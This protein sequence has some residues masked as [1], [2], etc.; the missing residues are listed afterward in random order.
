MISSIK[1]KFN[2]LC[3]LFVRPER[4][5]YLTSELGPEVFSYGDNEIK[6]YDFQVE[7]FDRLILEASVFLQTSFPSDF[8]ILY[9]HG[10]SGCRLDSLPILEY[11]G[12]FGINVAT[13][14]FSGTGISEGN[15]VTLGFKEWK[16]VKVIL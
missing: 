15:Y 9:L 8:C 6:R 12:E 2:D 10:N 4:F 7:N 16:D 14:D 5:S 11:F 3:H 1:K 13:F